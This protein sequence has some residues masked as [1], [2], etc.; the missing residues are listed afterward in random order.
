MASLSI[1]ETTTYRW[2]F[3]EDVTNYRAAGI[4]NMGVWRRKLSD[5]GEAKAADLLEESNMRVSC[6]F[7]VGGFT[8]SDGRSYK[9]SVDDAAETLKTA[10]EIGAKTVI[11]YSGGRAGHTFNHARRLVKGAL[12]ELA[13][14]ADQ[15]DLTLALEPMHPGCADGWTF[16]TSLDETLGLLD[17]IASPRVKLV[18]DT[19]HLGQQPEAVDRIEQIASR[20]AL[21]QLGDAKETP[22]G[23]QNR[24]LLGQGVVP[25]AQIVA[26]LTAGGY[27][28]HYDV[29]TLGEDVEAIDY[30]ELIENAKRVYADLLG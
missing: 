30:R 22:D 25:L 21:V 13:T 28:G 27:D 16:L 2:S 17:E 26:A 14:R 5:F 24:C 3:E 12:A 29:E 23:E 6:L 11:V 19:Y 18:F 1:N 20:V 8:G 4:Q 15:L 7:W 10:A 9:E